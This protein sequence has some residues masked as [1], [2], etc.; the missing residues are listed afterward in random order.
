[1]PSK[2]DIGARRKKRAK[3]GYKID[4]Y[5]GESP[6]VTT[7]KRRIA[8]EKRNI[9]YTHI[10]IQEGER[11]SNFKPVSARSASDEVCFQLEKE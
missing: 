7:E 9:E 1:M 5:Y 3:R 11:G 8:A 6:F 2:E 10:Y 4:I